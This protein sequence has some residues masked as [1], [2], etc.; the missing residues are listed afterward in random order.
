MKLGNLFMVLGQEEGTPLQLIKSPKM[1]YTPKRMD[2]S[3]CLSWEPPQFGGDSYTVSVNDF[4]NVTSST[5][6]H[7]SPMDL[8]ILTAGEHILCIVSDSDTQSK[9]TLTFSTSALFT[10]FCVTAQTVTSLSIQ[11]ELTLDAPEDMNYYLIAENACKPDISHSILL[12]PESKTK[13]ITLHHIHPEI[14]YNLYA[15]G[16]SEDCTKWAIPRKIETGEFCVLSLSRT[17]FD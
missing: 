3:I 9:C 15:V 12:N 7:F 4:K 13:V 1:T 11:Y 10:D 17:E 14:K 8:G 6:V 16:F 5:K 2:E